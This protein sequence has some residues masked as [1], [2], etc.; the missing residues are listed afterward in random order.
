MCDEAM[1]KDCEKF[2][3]EYYKKG[4]VLVWHD[5]FDKNEIDADKWIFWRT[6]GGTDRIYDN[7]KENARI[8][9]GKMLLQC[10]RTDDPEHPFTLSEGLTTKYTMNWKYGYL[11]MRAKIPFRHG[12]WPSFWTQS[13]TVFQKTPWMCETDIFEVFSSDRYAVANLHKWGMGKHCMLPGGEGS[14]QRGYKFENFENLN[15]EY[16]VYGY[17]WDPEYMTFYV[18]GVEFTKFPID[19]VKGN[20]GWD[21]IDGVMGF[22][23]FQFIIVN[24]EIFSEKSGWAPEGARIV[25]EDKLPFNYYIDWMRLYQNPEK[26]EI[27]LKPE[28]DEAL[29]AKKAAEENK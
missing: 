11:E 6:M 15:D 21:V 25:D 14:I 18:D 22:H 29:A 4:R 24:D 28:I 5:E 2:G 27:K 9:D 17:E 16:H 7:G 23:D 26:E 12:A 20:F 8:E 13:S 3:I 1:K 19:P 10:H